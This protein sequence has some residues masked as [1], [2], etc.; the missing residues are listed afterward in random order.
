MFSPKFKDFAEADVMK[1]FGRS[2]IFRGVEEIDRWQVVAGATGDLGQKNRAVPPPS[3]SN[4]HTH[5]RAHTN[6][7]RLPTTSISLILIIF[8]SIL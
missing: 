7:S 4:T 3:T 2:K 6:T 1:I 5:A 8:A